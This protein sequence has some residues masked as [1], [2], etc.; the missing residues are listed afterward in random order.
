MSKQELRSVLY[1]I[2]NM[3][4]EME[5]I[6]NIVISKLKNIEDQEENE[7]QDREQHADEVRE[8]L[9]GGPVR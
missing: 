5:R 1:N 4:A 6:R 3:E 9:R 7:R 8:R 2:T